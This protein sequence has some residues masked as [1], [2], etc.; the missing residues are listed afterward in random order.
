MTPDALAKSG[1]EHGEQRAL[2]AW[3]NMA[4]T[5]GFAAAWDD[6]SYTVQGHA[7]SLG[8]AP[9]EVLTMLHAI[10]NGGYRDKITAG[11]LKA[12][13]VKRGV[14]DIFLP[15]PK[16]AGMVA[17]LNGRST[18]CMWAGLYV[19]MKRPLTMKKGTR[20]D[21]I[22]DRAAGSTSVQQD[23]WIGKLRNV[24]YGVAVAFNWREA[25]KQI[26]SYVEWK[27]EHEAFRQVE[28]EPTNCAPHDIERV[29]A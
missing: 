28:R 18:P 26:Q 8:A 21:L 2:F 3:A 17:P 13:G 9:V 25:A 22:V 4:A 5:F 19:E 12:E 20:K 16:W 6:Q 11:K 23:E 29:S 15:L 10:P 27:V 24:G 14:P 7:A 1:S